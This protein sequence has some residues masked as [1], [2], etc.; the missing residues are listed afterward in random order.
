MAFFENISRKVT[1]TAKAAARKSG[2]I[3]EVTKLNM[4]IGAEEDRIKRKY[5]EI[6]KTVYEAFKKGEE[7]PY[8]FMEL[9]EKVK[10]YERNIEEMKVKVLELKGLKN[11]PSCGAELESDVAFCPK[12]GKKQEIPTRTV[13]EQPVDEDKEKEEDTEDKEDKEDN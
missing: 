4:N 3:V 10:E 12:C 7:I 6:G 13:E 2:D 1:D 8:P 9:C 5:S 11:C